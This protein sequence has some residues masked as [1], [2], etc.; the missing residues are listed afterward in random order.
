MCVGRTDRKLD[1]IT[2]QD[3]EGANYMLKIF[4]FCGDKKSHNEILQR[5]FQEAWNN[6]PGSKKLTKLY[7]MNLN[8]TYFAKLQQPLQCRFRSASLYIIRLIRIYRISYIHF[9][10][11]RSDITAIN[12]LIACKKRQ[13]RFVE[14][15]LESLHVHCLKTI[16]ITQI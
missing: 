11:C 16:I 15:V 3:G 8:L 14:F 13:A 6:E 10:S 12:L 9:W 4:K 7:I 1:R 5:S 2:G